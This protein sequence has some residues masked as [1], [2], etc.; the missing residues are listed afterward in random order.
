MKLSQKPTAQNDY[1]PFG[2]QMPGRNGTI[3]GGEYRYAFNG[4]E[5]D[6]A[7]SGTGNSYTTQFRQYDPRLGRWNS[8]DDKTGLYYASTPY[9]FAGN[10][11]I[12]FIDVDGNAIEIYGNRRYIKSVMS[13]LQ[14]LTNV[15][16]SYN[17]R[18]HTVDYVMPKSVAIPKKTGDQLITSLIDCKNTVKVMDTKAILNYFYARGV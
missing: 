18:T 4:M 17:S 5:T 2:M 16:L 15:K 3:S 11:P 7:V 10:S 12:V 14:K 13:E 1:Y 6:A 9:C 8:V